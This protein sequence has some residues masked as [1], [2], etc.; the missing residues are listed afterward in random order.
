MV[1]RVQ[2]EAAFVLH[3]RPFSE[4]SLLVDLFS[5]SYGRLVVIAKGARRLKSKHRGL[6]HPFSPLLVSWAGKGQLPTLTAAEISGLTH[7]LAGE[8]LMCGFYLNELVVRLLHRDDPHQALFTAY[9]ETIEGLSTS[10]DN[11]LLLRRFEITLLRELGYGLVLDAEAGSGDPLDPDQLYD[12]IPG[13]GPRV[14]SDP[15]KGT[16][17]VHGATLL[18]MDKADFFDSKTMIEGKRLLREMID[19]HLEGRPFHSRRLFHDVY[20]KNDRKAATKG[21]RS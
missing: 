18:A 10:D 6:L 9:R 11:E 8:S 17:V 5:S 19:R 1:K 20:R 15:E 16:I 14:I 21:E 3:R 12:Y 4:S 2:Q 7:P 13:H